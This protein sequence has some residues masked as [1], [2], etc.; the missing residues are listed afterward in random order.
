MSGYT[1]Q[2]PDTEPARSWLAHAPCKADAE[3]MFATTDHD[4][5][6]AKAVCR[7]CTVIEQ[8]RQWALDNRETFGTWGGLSERE[9]VAILRRRG[10]KVPAVEEEPPPARTFQSLY[11]ER[12]VALTD[13]HL[14][15]TGAIPVYCE[16]AYHTPAQIV[17]RLD[18]GRPAEGIVRRT[19]TREG[20]VLAAHLMDQRERNE[21][22]QVTAEVKAVRK[23][24]AARAKAVAS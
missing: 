20:C 18:R 22:Q 2:V 23:A 8:C 16:R 15:W 6:R 10:I 19:C 17:F 1:G 3:L 11:D 14:A 21:R 4:I 24:A 9:R 12:T 13:G 5:E 7:G